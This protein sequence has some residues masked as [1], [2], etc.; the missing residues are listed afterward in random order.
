[1]PD[2]YQILDL[3]RGA[4]KAQ[5]K[6]AYRKKAMECHPDRNPSAEAHAV[7]L[8]VREAYEALMG[9]PADGKTGS[10]PA[11]SGAQTDHYA[12]YE[13]VYSPEAEERRRAAKE[14][15]DRQTARQFEQ[16]R[17]SNEAFRRSWPY[18][19]LLALGHLSRVVILVMGVGCMVVAGITLNEGNVL[20]TLVISLPL[21]L[22]GGG[23]VYVPWRAYWKNRQ[24]KRSVNSK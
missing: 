24:S 6:K 18:R 22:I 20:A 21:F 7:F 9:P 17:R 14:R 4:S 2:Y 11:H 10:N 16:Y 12:F 13:R 8:R 1:M 15:V 19:L 3:P 23:M 5:I